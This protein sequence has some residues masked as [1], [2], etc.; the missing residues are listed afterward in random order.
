M[1]FEDDSKFGKET[2]AEL[3]SLL[4]GELVPDEYFPYYDLK[5]EVKVDREWIS[6]G[7]VAIEIGR[8]GKPAGLSITTAE[9]YIYKLDKL[10]YCNVEKLKKYLR[11]YIQNYPSSVINCGDGNRARVVLL[12]LTSFYLIFKELF[13]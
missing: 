9:Y 12:P 8:K 7:N 6:T 1:T 5:I 10:Y 2:E 4:G 11:E 3:Q 13:K